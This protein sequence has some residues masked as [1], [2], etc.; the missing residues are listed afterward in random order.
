[1][2]MFSGGKKDFFC[3]IA[4]AFEELSPIDWSPRLGFNLGGHEIVQKV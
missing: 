2:Y 4:L 1:M 3:Y